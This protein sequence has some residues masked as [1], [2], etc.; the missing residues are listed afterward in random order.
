[1]IEFVKLRSHCSSCIFIYTSSLFEIYLVLDTV[2]KDIIM[3]N[4]SKK[5]LLTLLVILT[6]SC[7][8]MQQVDRGLYG[9]ANSVTQRDTVTGARKFNMSG[10]PQQIQQGNANAIKLIE[11][12]QQKGAPLNAEIDRSQYNRL[13]RIFSRIHAVSHFKDENW[14]VYMIPDESFNAFTTGGSIVVVHYG[15]MQALDSDDA[16]A[17]V[18]GH[19]IAHV[20]AGHVFEA[21]GDQLA[22]MIT[23]SKSART[24]AYQAGYSTNNEKEA[25]EIGILYAALAGYNPYAASD[26][27]RQMYEQ[28][29]QD[30]QFYATHPHT[31][32]RAQQTQA[33]AQKAEQYY[34]QGRINPNAESILNGNALYQKR[35]E[36]A[37]AG[38]GGGIAAV[39]ETAAG[40][41]IDH[42]KAKAE[43]ARQTAQIAQTQEIQRSL[44]VVGD[45]D[46]NQNQFALGINY[47]GQRPV[48]GLALKAVGKNGESLYRHN[49]ILNPND[50]FGAVFSKQIL[51]N[52]PAENKQIKLIVDEGVLR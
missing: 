38:Q 13:T 49:G 17:A 11:A 4:I 43:G 22:A 28:H 35:G 18:I 29:G 12:Y 34:M 8:Q 23:G 32:D 40:F 36:I 46:V 21:K 7:A 50:T 24:N 48:A 33:I 9:I 37:Q 3:K 25:D 19:E 20:S 39:L 16:V 10:R 1:L 27:W 51:S 2:N 31:R 30:A 14:S 41:M 45:K 42:Q 15:L 26:V 6:T 44:R 47:S 5:I 52:N